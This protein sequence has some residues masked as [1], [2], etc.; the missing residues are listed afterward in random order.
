MPLTFRPTLLR[1]AAALALITTL[2]AAA[3]AQPRYAVTDLG[4]LP[5][6]GAC[7]PAALNDQG[8]VVGHCGAAVESP[9]TMGF[10]WRQG[11]MSA[12]GRLSGGTFS[13]ATAINAFGQVAGV[14]DT[15]N[16][17]PQG[18]VTTSAGLLNFFPNKGGNTRVGFLADAGW[19]GGYYTKSLSGWTSSWVPAIWKP[20]PKD[21]RKYLTIDLPVL[22]GGI[23]SKSRTSFPIAFNQA[24]Q[25]VGYG[26]NDQIGQHATLWN[27]DAAHSIV[28]IGVYPGDNAAV[29]YAI[30]EQ[31]QAVGTSNPPFGFRPVFWNN[32]PQHRISALPSLP[33]DNQGTAHAINS[34]GHVLG[35]S[36]YGTPGSWDATPARPVLWRDGGVH[37]LQSVL[38]PTSGAGWVMASAIAV[39]NRGQIAASGWL[40]G[41]ARAALLTPLN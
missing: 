16:G 19:I 11:A 28:D 1:R 6:W 5:G 17:R 34:L 14:G 36:F 21:A 27:N 8:D 4:S 30:N 15:G 13:Q 25:A 10:V 40:N 29:A 3:H 38:D 32:D 12:T 18:W 37:L 35:T 26:S 22:P 31:G 20:D 23:D 33:G 9:D 39:N 2:A 41:V 7:T 24:G